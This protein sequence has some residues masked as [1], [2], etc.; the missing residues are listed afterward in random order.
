M[1]KREVTYKKGRDGKVRR[2]A[3][4][5]PRPVPIYTP[6]AAQGHPDAMTFKEALTKL[7]AHLKSQGKTPGFR[8]LTEDVRDQEGLLHKKGLQDRLLEKTATVTHP[9]TK[10]SST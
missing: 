5:W 10:G 3:A 1:A 2:R 4:T 7:R 6:S 9:S 8:T